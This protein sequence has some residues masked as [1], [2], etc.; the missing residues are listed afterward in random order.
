MKSIKYII[1]IILILSFS[2]TTVNAENDYKKG[3]TI[4]PDYYYTECPVQGEVKLFYNEKDNQYIN[5]YL[6]YYYNNYSKYD[7]FFMLHHAGNGNY[8]SWID[9]PIQSY[10]GTLPLK[11]VYDWLIYEHKTPPF[12]VACIN[13]QLGV[14]NREDIRNAMHWIGDNLNT[15]AENGSDENLEKARYHFY[16]GGISMGAWKGTQC[17]R[18]DYDIFGNYIFGY[19]GVTNYVIED[20]SKE[21]AKTHN[22]KI[23]NNVI[24]GCG[25]KDDSFQSNKSSYILLSKYSNNCMFFEY[26]GGHTFSTAP[27][28]I[29][30]ALIFIYKDYKDTIIL[31]FKN[32][33]HK[34]VIYD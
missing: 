7:V 33:I 25:N 1:C 30:D 6:P 17:M 16:T 12:I 23:L 8:S 13:L 2:I 27:T 4:L 19:G 26:H 28:F 24:I 29:Y 22:N 32:I 18:E 10:G 9:T 11:Q 21:Y 20:L 34:K 15:Y 5:V 14:N 31:E 3:S